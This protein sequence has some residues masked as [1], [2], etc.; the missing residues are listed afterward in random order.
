MIVVDGRAADGRNK[1]IYTQKRKRKREKEEEKFISQYFTIP[2]F[3]HS[4][5]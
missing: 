5:M 4:L 2:M 3:S 1:I